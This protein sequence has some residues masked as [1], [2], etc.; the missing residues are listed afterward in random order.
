M[1]ALAKAPARMTVAEFM[2]WS[3]QTDGRWQ[4]VDGEPEA[5][6]PASR[7]HGTLQGELTRLIGNHFR[8]RPCPCVVVVEPGVVPY[9][10]S[11][12]NLRIPDLAV[13]CSDYG[14][15]EAMLADP[16]LIVEILLPTNHAQTWANVW[17]FTT[18]PS[19]REILILHSVT[20]GADLLR[21]QPDGNWPERPMHVETGSLT[22]ES[23]GMQ[24][25]LSDL[26]VNTRLARAPR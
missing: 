23:I 3:A 18:I 25:P 7:T 10:S 1:V 14:T 9:V 20:I 26:Y 12:Q 5:M 22:L 17:A 16:V 4:L 2:A 15:E 8:E 21:R 11:G 13:T 19:V 24:V 6:A